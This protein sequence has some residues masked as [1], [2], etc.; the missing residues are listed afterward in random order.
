MNVSSKLNT[1]GVFGTVGNGVRGEEIRGK[2]SWNILNFSKFQS[3]SPISSTLPPSK[4]RVR[5]SKLSQPTRQN[6]GKGWGSESFLNHVVHIFKL[7]EPYHP[8]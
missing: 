3:S 7:H 8:Y 2:I 5:H 1:K 4:H 6:P